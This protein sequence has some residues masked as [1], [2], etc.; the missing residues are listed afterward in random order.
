MWQRRRAARRLPAGHDKIAAGG[1]EADVWRAVFV[2]PAVEKTARPIQ[3]GA[4]RQKGERRT[5]AS[6][7]HQARSVAEPGSALNRHGKAPYPGPRTRRGG[8]PVAPRARIPSGRD[9]E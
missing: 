1:R 6:G 9:P 7:Q 8:V 5:P 2:R 4:C 3:T